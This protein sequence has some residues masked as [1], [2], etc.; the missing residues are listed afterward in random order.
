MR[1][2]E[3]ANRTDHH[4]HHHFERV[5]HHHSSSQRSPACELEFPEF[6]HK[7]KHYV[8]FDVRSESGEAED[9]LL[10]FYLVQRASEAALEAAKTQNGLL[11]RAQTAA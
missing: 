6:D 5:F 7:G 10:T 8:L 3:R 11:W 9:L 2:R 4:G 1:E